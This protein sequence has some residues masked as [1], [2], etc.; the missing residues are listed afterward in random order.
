MHQLCIAIRAFYPTMLIWNLKPY[1]RVAQCTFTAITSHAKT[2]DNFYLW[3][4]CAHRVCSLFWVVAVKAVPVVV[5]AAAEAV[6]DL[7]VVAV[8]Q[9]AVAES[10]VVVVD[11]VVAAV[12]QSQAHLRE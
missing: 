9:V 6:V 2:V 7:V 4:R 8:V 5:V 11:V 1:A 10:P 12:V 3:C